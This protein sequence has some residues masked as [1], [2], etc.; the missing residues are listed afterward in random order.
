MVKQLFWRKKLWIVGMMG[1]FLPQPLL[2]ETI[3]RVAENPIPIDW[4]DMA[5][6]PDVPSE[7]PVEIVGVEVFSTDTGIDL[8]LATSGGDIASV[9]FSALENAL[10]VEIPNAVLVLP[11]AEGFQAIAPTEN[12]TSVKLENLAGDRVRVEIEGANVLPDAEVFAD[13][14]HLILEVNVEPAIAVEDNTLRILVTAQRT[15][16][17]LQEVPISITVLTEDTI[18]DADIVNLEGI[19]QNTPNFSVYGAAGSRS[20]NYYNIR[21]LSNFNFISRDAVGFYIDDL[22][23]DYGGFITQNL[24]DLERVEVLR[25]PQSTLYGRSTQ[26]GA[27][28]IISRRPSNEFEFKSAIAYGTFN[29]FD[30]RGSLSGPL[31]EDRLFYRLSGS[32]GSRDGYVENTFLGTDLDSQSGGNGRGQILWTPSEAWEILMNASFDDYRDGVGPSSSVN[33]DPFSVERDVNGFSNLNTNAQSLRV[34][35][36]SPEFRFTSITSRR[37][38]RQEVETDLD[39]SAIDT[40]RFT[41]TFDSTVITQE[42]RLQSPTD[43]DRWQWLLGAYF[44]SRSFNTEDDGFQ[45]G[46]LAALVFG[47]TAISGSSLLR[48]AEVDENIWAGFGQISYKPSQNLTLTAGLRYEAIQSKLDQFDRVLT[49]PDGS[50]TTLLSFDNIEQ[51]GDILLP[52]FALEYQID[53]EMMVYGSISRGY[54]PGGVNYRP[55]NEASLTFSPERSWNYEIGW[56]SSWLENRLSLDLALFHNPISDYQVVVLDALTSLPL[57]ITNADAELT[58]FEMQLRATPVEGF[59][60][61]AGLGFVDATFTNYRDSAT[62]EVFDGNKLPFSSDLTYNLALQYRDPIGLF[63][64]AEWVGLGTTYFDEAN[65]LTQPAYGI[66][67]ARLGYETDNYGIYLFGNNIFNVEYLTAAFGLVGSQTNQYGA[68]ATF[69]VQFRAEF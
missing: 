31:V 17:D 4:G 2:A 43:A 67:N 53:P 29:D 41:N 25:G 57:E 55:D 56:K 68:P 47:N 33:A 34:A 63:V 5:Q 58:G 49:L 39:S 42:L 44:E 13:A 37:F 20:F 6:L 24:I 7:S 16:E 19:A 45:F 10:I 12:I 32:Y 40:G 30:W 66:F 26:A 61:V 50:T 54:R 59:D 52:R 51:S 69:G 1:V 11:E 14:T 23:Y 21:G 8:I 9:T 38:S 18:E 35:Y 36:D 15:E 60:I 3:A 22:P 62:G 64:R 48:S 65:T 27:V 28:N 46:D